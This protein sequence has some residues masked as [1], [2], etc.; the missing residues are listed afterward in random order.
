M[1]NENPS[2]M[3]WRGV[4]FV[5]FLIVLLCSISPMIAAEPKFIGYYAEWSIYQRDYHVKDMPADQLTHINYAF[6][7]IVNGEC[8]LVDPFAA[9]EK[10]YPGDGLERGALR[11]NFNQ[12]LALKK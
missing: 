6:A 4:G 11:G 10:T 12:L 8:A 2:K 7:K 3:R 9:V 1:R 5:V